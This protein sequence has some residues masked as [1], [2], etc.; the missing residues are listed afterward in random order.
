MQS[1]VYFIE[2]RLFSFMSGVMTLYDT[3]LLHSQFEDSEYSG[4]KTTL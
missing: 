2:F 1:K 4:K 3:S